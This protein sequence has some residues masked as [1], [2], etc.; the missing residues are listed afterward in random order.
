MEIG[1]HLFYYELIHLDSPQM[2]SLFKVTVFLFPFASS[3]T[4]G[5]NL[6]K[7]N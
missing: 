2:D 7:A 1:F 4:G 3:F 5:L 6:N